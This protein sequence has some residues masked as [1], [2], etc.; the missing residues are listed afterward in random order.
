MLLDSVIVLG[1][2]LLTV[3]NDSNGLSISTSAGGSKFINS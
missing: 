2:Q 3:L 1:E